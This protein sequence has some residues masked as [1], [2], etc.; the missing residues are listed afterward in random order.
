MPLDDEVKQ[1]IGR[2]TDK[3][4]SLIDE[5][6]QTKVNVAL[7][8]EPGVGK[9]SLVNAIVG[10]RVAETGATGETTHTAQAVPHDGVEGLVFWDL[11]GCGTPNHPRETFIE[12]Q[13][14]LTDYD[15]YVLVTEKRIRQGDEWL[16]WPTRA[17]SASVYALGSQAP[18]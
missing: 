15:V 1:E 9:S 7:I 3:S 18:K 2:L 12:D 10:K 6:E 11:P 13:K 14:L 16:G 8:G 5:F 17:F 4:R